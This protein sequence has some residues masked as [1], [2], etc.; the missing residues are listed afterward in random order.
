MIDTYLFDWG[1]TLMV[2]F[3][4]KPGKMCDWDRVEAVEGAREVLQAL[5]RD[6][7]IYVATGAEASTELDIQ[8]AFDRV[9]LG[10]FISGYF[11]L[12]NVGARKGSVDFLDTILK[13]IG[14]PATSVAMVGDSLTKD[15]E[16]AAAIG[17]QPIWFSKNAGHLAPSTPSTLHPAPNPSPS[18]GVSNIRVIRRLSDLICVES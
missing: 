16:P 9:D 1:D 8:R 15:I 4:D 3:P 13:R 6:C 2:D 11:C 14:K 5:S 10:E 18:S 7:S 12:S 17:I